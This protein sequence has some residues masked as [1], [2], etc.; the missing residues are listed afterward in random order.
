M[1]EY[2]VLVVS[3]TNNFDFIYVGERKDKKILL[4]FHNSHFDYIKSLSAFF[5]CDKFCF[6]CLLPYQTDLAHKCI[7]IFKLCHQKGCGQE[8]NA[9]FI[10]SKCKVFCSDKTS[11]FNHQE[12]VCV[13]FIKCDTCGRIRM[14]LHMCNGR[15]C[16]NCAL[17]VPMDHPMLRS[18]TI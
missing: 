14:K 5:D 10:G 3:D 15:W 7:K 1:K 9:E 2:Q 16:L 12:K 18:D 8:K 17:T 11:L 4:F 6:I 13:K